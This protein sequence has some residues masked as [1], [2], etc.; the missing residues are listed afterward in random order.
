MGITCEIL[1]MIISIIK[2]LLLPPVGLILLALVGVAFYKRKA[3][4]RVATVSLLMLLILSLPIVVN[5]LAQYWECYSAL[6]PERVEPFLPQAIVVIGGGLEHAASEYRSEW[7]IKS[8]TLVRLRYAAKL[9]R[10]TGL[11]ILVSGGRTLAS[12]DVSE[13]QVMASVLQEE[14]I[15]PN[16][17]QEAESQNTA[18]NA[19]LSRDFLRQRG[20]ERI[21]LVTQAYH[22]PRAESEFRK[23][24]FQ[25]LPAPTAFIGRE[26]RHSLFDWIPSVRSFEHVFLLTHESIGM[27]WY[28]LRY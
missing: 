25:V 16:V 14:F 6:Q 7:T 13:A 12:Q 28:R 24:G 1:V 17:W 23:V 10:E 11:P 27:L 5:K 15:I 20:I 19:R 3:G 8:G 2:S 26:V 9:A 4:L 18:E 22:M 21:I